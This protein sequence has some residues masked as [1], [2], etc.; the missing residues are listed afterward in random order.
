[1]ASWDDYAVTFG[2]DGMS[3]GF[4][5]YELAYYAAGS[6]VF[7][8]S[9]DTLDPYLSDY[10]RQLLEMSVPATESHES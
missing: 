2:K 4:S 10:G 5:P 7:L 8:I 6:Q 9:Y 3:V 1:M